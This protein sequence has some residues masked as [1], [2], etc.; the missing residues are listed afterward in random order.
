MDT[1]EPL[2]TIPCSVKSLVFPG[3]TNSL[4]RVITSSDRVKGIEIEVFVG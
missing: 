2:K 3:H 4:A 1:L